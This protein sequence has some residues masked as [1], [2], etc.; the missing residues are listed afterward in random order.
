MQ[1]DRGHFHHRLLDAGFSVR[2]IF[3]LYL[4]VSSLTAVC[5]LSLWHAGVSEAVLFF[6]FAGLSAAWLLGIRNAPRLVARLPKSLKRGRMPRL[7]RTG[8]SEGSPKS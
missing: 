4:V 2:A 8:R 6:A 1:A 5:G 7:F 3:L